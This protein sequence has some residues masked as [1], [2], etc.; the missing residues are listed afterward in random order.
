MKILQGPAGSGK[1]FWCLEQ[2]RRAQ[3]EGD[4]DRVHLLVPAQSAYSM[5]AALPTEDL[6]VV[7]GRPVLTFDARSSGASFAE[8]ALEGVTGESAWTEA[9]SEVDQ[10]LRVRRMLQEHPPGCGGLAEAARTLGF[11]QELL[12]LFR[13]WKE[14][15]LTPGEIAGAFGPDAR[16]ARQ[17]E[18][19][20]LY[21][22]H[23]DDLAAAGK[24]DTADLQRRALDW[25]AAH[26]ERLAGQ[27]FLV[28]SFS[29]F[30][31]W[32]LEVLR[33]LAKRAESLT[34]AFPYEEDRPWVFEHLDN[35]RLSLTSH[36][37]SAADI[38]TLSPPRRFHPSARA[39]A[40]LERGLY[41]VRPGG[42]PE[43]DSVA[44][45]AAAD[46][47]AELEEIARRIRVLVRDHGYRH[48]EI[49]VLFRGLQAS[50][51]RVQEIFRARGVPV[52]IPDG[53]EL[54]HT[55][56]ARAARQLLRLHRS[57]ADA[58]TA[59]ALFR[60]SLVPGLRDD[61]DRLEMRARSEGLVRAARLLEQAPALLGETSP[62]A[63]VARALSRLTSEPG[64][65]DGAGWA[66]R[67]REGLAALGA[68][69][70]RRADPRLFL[71]HHAEWAGVEELLGHLEAHFQG[72][73]ALDRF[74]AVFLELL[75]AQPGGEVPH[76]GGCV[77]VGDVF[78]SRLPEVRA[79]F[80]PGLSEGLFPAPVSEDRLLP[81][82]DRRRIAAHTGRRLPLASERSLEEYYFFYVAVTRASER[83]CLSRPA[84][85]RDGSG[86][87]PSPF[88]REAARALGPWLRERRVTA[89][90]AD[91]AN[92]ADLAE[93]ESRVA[94]ELSRPRAE[95]ERV[96][97][98]ARALYNARLSRG[99]PSPWEMPEAPGEIARLKRSRLAMA[100]T[101]LEIFAGCPF[102]HF[103][104]FPL[105]LREAR[106]KDFGPL[107]DGTLL[108]DV[109]TRCLRELKAAGGVES[110]GGV[111]ALT[112]R[113]HEL[114]D[115]E[116]RRRLPGLV[117]RPLWKVRVEMLRGALGRFARALWAEHQEGKWI[118]AHFQL[119]FGPGHRG[120][121]PADPASLEAP[122]V[123]RN[124]QVELRLS[125]R[126]D[127][128]DRAA[129]DPSRMR[130]LD[131][132]RS[133][134]SSVAARLRDGRL[135]QAN[136][137]RLALAAMPGVTA[138]TVGHFHFKDGKFQ[139]FDRALN[140]GRKSAELPPLDV[141]D[142]TRKLALRLGEEIGAGVVGVRPA[143]GECDFC[144]YISVCRVDQWVRVLAVEQGDD[145]TAAPDAA[146]GEGEGADA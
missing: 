3:R 68:E 90:D 47:D 76:L 5:R 28:D 127:R 93:L 142:H 80:L 91:F 106:E 32:Q 79:L 21:A 17:R 59:M 139:D 6:R 48:D 85:D 99:G 22:L 12:R 9:I 4:W 65:R 63:P 18:L 87:Q 114:L 78:L 136:L 54:L 15:L 33:L 51:R 100:P 98:E 23:R 35:D 39:I 144:P 42:V 146:S 72:P 64:P 103:A 119:A 10:L 101:A 75:S 55:A 121:V 125:G 8:W 14:A 89:F 134:R 96:T 81:D 73:V 120:T 13:E 92:S 46:P 82:A 128:V 20:R 117:E 133:A 130:I 118:P 137:Y 132:K 29:H 77:L 66:G 62:L 131:Y 34:V 11:A 104:Q 74:E 86:L 41:Q 49:A 122:L 27:R 124:E 102:R 94:L 69:D 38:R 25:L 58:D 44:C 31:H 143:S 36:L 50:R 56:P 145:D 24:P 43:D 107:E 45:F 97:A 140:R 16:L 112:A 109:A 126:M 1:T 88:L 67:V 57:T 110:T 26:P 105:R 71:R 135:L 129:D 123:L 30:T 111:E 60:S 113:L 19:A 141:E 108:D 37:A 2:L 115:E 83:L 116:V 138:E 52:F 53:E 61:A 95:G 84:A 70:A 40:G 7:L